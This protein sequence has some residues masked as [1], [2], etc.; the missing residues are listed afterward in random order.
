MKKL[1]LKNVTLC[2]T[3]TI[4]IQRQLR[5]FEICINYADFNA[6][7]LFTNCAENYITDSGVQV[8]SID[9]VNSLRDYNNF[10]LKHLNTYIDTEFVMIAEYDGFI[11][12]PDAWMDEFLKYDYIGAPWLI[13]NNLVVGN[14]GFSIRSKKLLTLTQT[15]DSIQLGQKA[16]HQYAENEDWVIGVVMREYIESKGIQFAP[17][18]LAKRFSLEKNDEV[19][20]VWTG[21]FGFHGLQWTDISNWLKQNPEHK[22]DNPVR[23]V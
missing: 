13:D 19:G 11:L 2:G 10:N 23:S 6:V 21:Q 12:N 14:G 8:I 20:G 15:D 1:D 18:E 17:V 4:D 3:D 9:T 7:K 16:D 5:A 22:I